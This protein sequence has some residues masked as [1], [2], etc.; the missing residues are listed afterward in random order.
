MIHFSV[1][2]TLMLG[3][4]VVSMS[5]A[6]ADESGPTSEQLGH[7]VEEV[8]RLTA[9][10]SGLA[11]TFEGEGIVADAT[12]FERVC[13]PVGV[14]A[15]RVAKTNG[16]MLSQLAEKYRNPGHQLDPETAAVF[17]QMAKEPALLGLWRRSELHGRSGIRYFRRIEVEAACLAC[18]GPKDS[19]PQFIKQNY[20]DDRAY[21]FRPG[22]LRGVFTVFV[23]AETQLDRR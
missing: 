8:E 3:M 4:I 6:R 17:R 16:W 13:K 12:T 1:L 11:L 2:A 23:P 18:H 15:K 14:E 19:R 5:W 9:M 7:V 21:N 10:R 20:P 22:D